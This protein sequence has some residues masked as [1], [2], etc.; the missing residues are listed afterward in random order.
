MKWHRE[1]L[2]HF[3]A[4]GAA[5]FVVHGLVADRESDRGDRIDVTAADVERLAGGWART[6]QRPPTEQELAGLIED[7]IREEIFY[8]EALALGLDR[9]DTIIRRRLRQKMEFISDDIAAAVE[10]TEAALAAFL[11]A[12]PDK[13]RVE[14]RFSFRHVYLNRDRRGDAVLAETERLLAEL[15]RDLAA[16]P[17]ELGDPFLLPLG[18]RSQPLSEV[19][20]VFGQLFATRLPELETGRW[21]GPVE[22][23]YGVHLVYVDERVEGRDPALDEVR[24][25]VRTELMAKRREE[26]NE[27][28][29]ARLRERY[30]IEIE[31]PVSEMAAVGEVAGGS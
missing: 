21:V 12:N 7:S 27:S 3:L 30:E 23:G 17:A 18:Y 11:T 9:D 5:L 25:A 26:V 29:Y 1:P 31:E 19:A 20:K 14:P 16:D 10:P 6:W 4:L 15:T 13:F 8:R 24:D 2:F 22:S 28:F